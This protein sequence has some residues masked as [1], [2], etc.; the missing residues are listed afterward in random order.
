MTENANGTEIVNV[1]RRRCK[2]LSIRIDSSGSIL[3]TVPHG[4][5]DREIKKLLA[6]NAA[7]IAKK[8]TEAAE[9]LLK[10]P[11]PGANE[12]FYRGEVW[13]FSPIPSRPS[14][15]VAD[16]GNKIISSGAIPA[17]ETLIKWYKKEAAFY[18]P[19]RVAELAKEHG[20]LYAESS[21]REA[22]SRWGSCSTR[23]AI[24]LNSKLILA[25]AWVS[26]SII[27][28]ELCH[29]LHHNHGGLFREKLLSVC[30]RW[31]EAKEWLKD[32]H[33]FIEKVWYK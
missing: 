17:G 13:R 12:L 27:L 3:V 15:I 31:D 23:G 9:R 30:P 6:K 1:S 2:R 25:P 20:F 16:Y 7:W 26:D 24:S 18:L 8:R 10:M 32:H 28:H 29:T 14:H 4:V 33:A 5:P 22:K 19:A 21:V 11:V